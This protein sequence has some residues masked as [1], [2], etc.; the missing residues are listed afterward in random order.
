MAGIIVYIPFSVISFIGSVESLDGIFIPPLVFSTNEIPISPPTSENRFTNVR[1][2][3]RVGG[4]MSFPFEY[5]G[6]IKL[7]ANRITDS[8]FYY[9]DG[10]SSNVDNH[11]GPFLNFKAD[12]GYIQFV[13]DIFSG[14][15]YVRSYI[16]SGSS[17]KWTDW[18]SIF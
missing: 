9:A 11:I 12:Q 4:L 3:V 14:S 16:L 7:D 13:S 10:Q 15:V 1:L 18:H 8:G 2:S 6:R 5:R 17:M